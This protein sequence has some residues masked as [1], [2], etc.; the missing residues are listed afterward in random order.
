MPSYCLH[1]FGAPWIERD[2][3]PVSI[4][5]RKAMALLAY[6]IVTARA[7]TRES[8]A[9]LLWPESDQSSALGNLRRDLSG[10]KSALGAE[11][12][13]V[14][15]LNISL[16]PASDVWLDVTEFQDRIAKVQAH[17]GDSERLCPE[18]FADLAE[19]IALYTGDFMSGFNLPDSPQFD[20]WQFFQSD[21]LRQALAEGLQKLVHYHSDKGEYEQ[22]IEF[23][24]RWLSLDLLHE[25]AHR[26]LMALYALSGQ[27]AAAL[28]QYQE[29]V[30]I[31]EEEL[32]ISPEAETRQ[33]HETI[34]SRKFPPPQPGSLVRHN[35]PAQTTQFIGREQ[36]LHDL[37]RLLAAEP[38]VRLTT[39]L[40]P[41]GI[42]KT[43]L[44]VEAARL[45]AAL[46]ADGVFFVS[47]TPLNSA[48]NIL[49]ALADS[50]GVQLIE[51]EHPERQLFDFL[52]DKHML[53]VLDNFEHLLV[54]VEF[55]ADILT[56]SPQVELLVTSRERLD[57]T[58]ENL[59]RLDGMAYPGQADME[60]ALEYDAISLLV[61]NVRRVQPDFEP[62]PQDLP[63]MVR[64][65]QLVQGMPLALVLAASWTEV[66]SLD[67]ISIEIARSL[68]ILVTEMRD[69]P[70]RQRSMYCVFDYSWELLAEQQRQSLMKLCVFQGGFT[71]QVAQSVAGASMK[72][73]L[74][75]INKSWLQR[76][77]GYRYHFHELVRQYA[78]QKLSL[79]PA[80][81]HQA[82]VD[83][84]AYY[85]RLMQELHS[86]MK[87]SEQQNAFRTISIEFDNI[88]AAWGWLVEQGQLQTVIDSI[89]PA[90]FRYCEARAR[91]FELVQLIRAARA[92]L[93]DQD[94]VITDQAHAIMLTAQAAFFRNLYPVR[95]EMF[96][97]LIPAEEDALQEAWSLVRQTKDFPVMGF[98]GI[99]LSFL[100]GRIIDLDRGIQ[101]LRHLAHHF[102]QENML[103]EMAFALELLIQLLE[104]RLNT[105][106]DTDEIEGFA[107]QAI[108]IFQ[109]LGDEREAGFTLRL[110][111]QLHRL[112]HNYPQA[113]QYWQTAQEKLQ[114]VGDWSTAAGV[115]WQLGDLHLQ[116]GAI[117]TAFQHYQALSQTYEGQGARRAAAHMLSKE[118]YE[119]LRY[120]DVDHAWRTRQ[121]SLAYAREVGDIFSEAWSIWELGE[122][123]RLKGDLA[124]ARKCYQEAKTLLDRFED[125]NGDTFYHRGMGD[126]ALA[127]DDFAEAERQFSASLESAHAA[128]HHWGMS[129]ALTGLG[130]AWL[131][132]ENY[133]AA[134]EYFREAL[135]HAKEADELGVALVALAGLAALYAATAE[136]KRAWNLATQV[137]NHHVSWRETREIAA[138]ILDAAKDA[139]PEV[140]AVK[141]L[142]TGNPMDLWPE[143]D[144]LLG[145]L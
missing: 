34:R 27:H 86:A 76:D 5:R 94:M 105:G 126:V 60:R 59:Y 25:P 55:L 6:L 110:F 16:N 12:L 99:L 19:A 80:A 122:I 37:Q 56:A 104:M 8:L 66:L 47:L 69:L 125:P 132:L 7:H 81:H 133:G 92:I 31:L 103:W 63:V 49:F 26:Q 85:A 73:L 35:L 145:E 102:Q 116:M 2:A 13:L 93:H 23:A 38:D 48:K 140:P 68:D 127:L 45:V 18:C 141:P 11:L 54:G 90:L 41:G 114:S 131:G 3:Q 111:G 74:L 136:P 135:Q 40:G 1:L 33:L 64:I 32:G 51:A 52:Q 96:G 130:R 84:S 44:A 77:Q 123:Y 129:Y 72:D 108:D 70:E 75:L 4:P 24:R 138:S 95:L 79:D 29:C 124:E 20:D 67:E 106:V 128:D 142:E 101:V 17:H 65:C 137:L 42:G 134:R 58:S 46:F 22:A 91:S 120:S 82:R 28:R 121:R 53:L 21:G 87:G 83:H 43:R 107:L 57:L 139:L 144:R 118:S 100:Y 98:W 62:Q 78:E 89:L 119:A 15:R 88:R 61:Q 36:E 117:A 109:N 30:R 10:L 113:I 14:E 112:Q 143:L 97:M 50:I 39:I 71:R 115:H 9:T